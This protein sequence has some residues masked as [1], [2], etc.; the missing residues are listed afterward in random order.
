MGGASV[1]LTVADFG[2]GV[3]AVLEG[4]TYGAPK[5]R[6]MA[7]GEFLAG[8]V[9]AIRAGYRFDQGQESHS[10][11]A[12]LGYLDRRFSVDAAFRRTIIGPESMAIVF[13]FSLHIEALNMNVG[14][15][16]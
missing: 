8:D 2:L 5:V 13:G 3:D 9:V 4:T 1:A 6:L 15:I 12:G 11:S 10:V 7:G 14:A 16:N